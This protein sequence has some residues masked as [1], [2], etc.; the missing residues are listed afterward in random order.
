MLSS[1]LTLN[2]L[3]FTVSYKAWISCG[4]WKLILAD[5]H[6]S[7]LFDSYLHRSDKSHFDEECHGNTP[8]LRPLSV[9]SNWLSFESG[10]V[11]VVT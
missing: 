1:V 2:P 8:S 9:I 6:P 5:T 11:Q 4:T 7:T 10:I 3:F